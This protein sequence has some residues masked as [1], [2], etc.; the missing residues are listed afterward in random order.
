MAD[1]ITLLDGLTLPNR[2]IREVRVVRCSP[3][4]RVIND[5]QI[6]I[7][8]HVSRGMAVPGLDI[9]YD[10]I[11]RSE[12]IT[13][14]RY[15]NVRSSMATSAIVLGNPAR[16]AKGPNVP[17]RRL[18]RKR[19]SR[20]ACHQHRHREQQHNFSPQKP[21]PS[22]LHEHL[23]TSHSSAI[24]TRQSAEHPNALAK[25]LSCEPVGSLS[26][27]SNALMSLGKIPVTKERRSIDHPILSR[28]L[29]SGRRWSL[30]SDMSR[31]N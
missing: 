27:V 23:P 2:V 16:R 22:R 8:L 11:S 20:K 6:A 30:S 7:G 25:S 12:D 26:P 15:G 4:I 21:E 31:S 1:H 14:R 5:N 13:T 19:R 24:P 17:R 10:T 9:L 18:S 28:C 29:S 3:L